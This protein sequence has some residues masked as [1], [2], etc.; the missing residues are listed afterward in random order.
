MIYNRKELFEKIKEAKSR[1]RVLGAVSFDLPYEDFRQDWI[2]RI[3]NGELHVEIVCESESDLT[4]SS[5]LSVNKRISGHERSYDIGTLM[6][7]K[8]EPKIKLR[9]YLI[10]N[11]CKHV[12]PQ[13]ENPERN[14]E[15][16]P[17]KDGKDF[18]MAKDEK[19]CFSLRTCFWRIPIPTINID[20]DY[21]YTLSL[22]KFCTQEKFVKISLNETVTEEKQDFQNVWLNEF[23][24]YFKAYFD[25]DKGAKK[26]SSE[27]TTKDNRTE[28]I[29]M[30][31]D[32]RHCLGQLPRSSFLNITKAKVVIW[33]MIF[34]RDG[35]VLIHKRSNN[36][37]DNRGM[38]DKSI[39]GHV[40]MEKDT[41]DTVKA[42]SREMLE[43]LY[44]IEAKDQGDHSKV[45]IKEINTDKPIFLGEWREE[46]R[47]TLPFKEI[48]DKKDD[49]YFFRMNYSFSKIAVDSP[50]V[51]PD[52][53]ES[54]VKCF[55]D[56][57]VFIMDEGFDE[58]KLENSSFKLLE[59]YELYDAF[60]GEDIDYFDKDTKEKV[61]EPFKPTPDLKKIITTESLWAELSTF[62]DYLKQGLL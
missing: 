25:E 20:D 33:G 43:E 16:A 59:L 41:V 56:M 18:I 38:W 50:R 30:Y 61:V 32:K 60:M 29:L 28:T 4:Y 23:K 47:T 21:Y 37:K 62:S 52:K 22:T 45:G 40:D 14:E 34:T 35:R 13:G 57:Y 58:K 53:S 39:G 54:P 27:I 10:K 42:A 9:D 51:L 55:A 8:N 15:G 24:N 36:A 19:Q 11:S 1:I 44:K 3:N 2:K 26:Y 12:E 7:I 46:L 5:L 6:R 48:A 49:M 17:I 31:N